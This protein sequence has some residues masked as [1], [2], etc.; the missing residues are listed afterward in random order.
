MALQ[1]CAHLS[2]ALRALEAVA[3]PHLAAAWDNTG[4]LVEATAHFAAATAAAAPAP[5]APAAAYRVFLTNDLTPAVLREA[6]EWRCNLIVAYHP[7]VF[8]AMKRFTSGA[9][10]AA[11]V[12]LQCAR[13]G[14]AVYSPH[15]ALDS[16]PGGINDWL[17]DA[18]F[19]AMGVRAEQVAARGPIKPAAAVPAVDGAG[20]GRVARLAQPVTAAAVVA[21]V[22]AALGLESVQVALPAEHLA[23]SREGR[24]SVLAAA[25]GVPVGT[26]AVCAGSG[27][28]VLAGAPPAPGTLYLT[29]EMSH[30]E[31]L[32]ANAAG[33]TVVLTNHS[34]CERGYLPVL[35]D[36]LQQAWGQVAAPAVGGTPLEVAVS[37]VDADPLVGC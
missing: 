37:A 33:A 34:N 26:I 23:A 36:R 31:V 21:G 1:R 10:H 17:L 25:E 8:A 3:P 22:K 6:L 15:T 30:H 27:G 18:L 4:L 5:P 20:D 11:Q 35:R 32:A 24:A 16:V 2:A 13:A 29:G 9:G 28:S 14:V 12:V 7:P 19:D